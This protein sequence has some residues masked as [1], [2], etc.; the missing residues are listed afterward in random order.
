M[1]EWLTNFLSKGLAD[2]G[3]VFGQDGTFLPAFLSLFFCARK[4]GKL[5]EDEYQVRIVLFVLK[6]WK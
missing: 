4:H 1:V 2:E 6:S 5:G 3:Q